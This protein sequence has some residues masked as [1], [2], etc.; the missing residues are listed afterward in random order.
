MSGRV[1]RLTLSGQNPTTLVFIWCVHWANLECTCCR[2]ILFFLHMYHVTCFLSSCVW[3]YMFLH[4]WNFCSVQPTE[5]DGTVNL[6][7]F[8]VKGIT[9]KIINFKTLMRRTRTKGYVSGYKM[10]N[11]RVE[12]VLCSRFAVK[13]G[14]PESII[15]YMPEDKGL[16][17][18]GFLD[19]S[20]KWEAYAYPNLM[21]TIQ[22]CVCQPIWFEFPS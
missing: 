8:K 2:F 10:W 3:C 9:R 17:G 19:A 12:A 22:L 14:W 16:C 6:P 1:I 4:V 18:T 13:S 7:W 15:Q 21:S 5:V 11:K 20:Y